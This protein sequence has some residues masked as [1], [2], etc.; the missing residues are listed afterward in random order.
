MTAHAPTAPAPGTEQE[1]AHPGVGTYVK[2]GIVLFALTAAEV[3]VYEFG[4][5]HANAGFGGMLHPVV[6]P[7]LLA[8]SA[9][10]FALVAMFYMHL[11]QDGKL[12]TGVF[13]FPLMIAAVVI[14][15]L[16][17]LFAYHHAFQL[18]LH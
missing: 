18:K 6:V 17:V 9:V 11:K 13:V 14:V 5:N 8:L 2:V 4:Y 7:V 3:A 16:I 12:F 1:H 15:A 10:K